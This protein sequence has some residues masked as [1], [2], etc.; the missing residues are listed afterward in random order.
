M[1][2]KGEFNGSLWT[3]PFELRLYL[4]PPPDGSFCSGADKTIQAMTA[5]APLACAGF[6][7]I[8]LPG[9]VLGYPFNSADVRVFM[10]LYGTTLYLR[11]DKVPVRP[12]ILVA[13]F[14]CLLL[15]GAFNPSAFF[16]AYV[17]SL[18]PLVL[19]LAY[20][21]K[22]RVR[23]FNDWGDFSYGVYIY[24]FPISAGVPVSRDA[25]PGD[26]RLVGLRQP[27]RRG[28][29]L[30]PHR[31]A[32]A[33]AEGRLR[34]GDV[35]RVQSRPGE[36]RRRRALTETVGGRS[37]VGRR[38]FARDHKLFNSLG[39]SFCNSATR[40]SKLTRDRLAWPWVPAGAPLRPGLRLD[41][42]V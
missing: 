41:S 36:D 35:P 22:G 16:V 5:I 3:L 34:L 26:G 9:R 14:A 25:A 32:R 21:P 23:S 33:G 30:D 38:S 6:L 18:A 19:H 39:A 4:Y 31:K 42:V 27:R 7:V 24:A 8:I 29:V 10:F 37:R 12:G 1:P 2:L 13:T 17:F 11:R 15:A 40:N 28:A 20:L